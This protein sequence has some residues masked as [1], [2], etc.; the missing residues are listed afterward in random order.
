MTVQTLWCHI[1]DL[2]FQ[3]TTSFTH[4]DLWYLK[5]FTLFSY[6]HIYSLLDRIYLPRSLANVTWAS[7]KYHL[8]V[9]IWLPNQTTQFTSM[10]E[11]ELESWS[12]YKTCLWS[13][14]LWQTKKD[15]IQMKVTRIKTCFLIN[16]GICHIRA[17]GL[18]HRTM[19]FSQT[20]L[21]M[22][23]KP[24]YLIQ[25]FIQELF[26]IGETLHCALLTWYCKAALV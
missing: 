7:R 16:K 25:L 22:N 20:D 3:I 24:I 10:G 23:S 18:Q 19:T 9:T 6:N 12:L 8:L 1:Y 5:R 13:F 17:E 15:W 11:G 4:P 26:T 21:A 2:I 14:S